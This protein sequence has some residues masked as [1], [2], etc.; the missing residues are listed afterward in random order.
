MDNRI[1]RLW[2][3]YKGLLEQHIKQTNQE[4]IE[5][6][7]LVKLIVKEI[8]NRGE[9]EYDADKITVIDN[10]DYQGTQIFIIP[11]DIYQPEAEWYLVTYAEYGS[12]SGCDTIIGIKGYEGGLPDEEQ[13]KDYMTLCLH[14]IQRMK[15]LYEI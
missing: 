6:E 2:D 5:Y 14:L 7:F 1:I 12:C 11:R 15:P 3:E 8:I 9:I 10:G 4:E 13:V